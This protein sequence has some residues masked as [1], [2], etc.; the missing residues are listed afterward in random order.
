MSQEEDLLEKG[1]EAYTADDYENAISFWKKSSE[2][3]NMIAQS[4]LGS[5]YYQGIG[6]EKDY[7]MAAH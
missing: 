2:D 3:G 4:N 7:L 5:M 6:V 1:L